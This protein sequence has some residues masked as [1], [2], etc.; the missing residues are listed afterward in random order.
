MKLQRKTIA[1]DMDGVIADVE[2]QYID[3]YKKD[4]GVVIDPKSMEGL[5]EHEAVPEA[6]AIMKF[7]TTPGFFRT[8]PVME[9]AV[10]ALKDLM[11]DYEVYIVSAAMEFPLSLYEKHQWLAEHFP[12]ISWKNIIFCGDKSVI[13][14]DYMIDDHSK[15]LDFHQGKTLMFNSFHNHGIEQHPRVDNWQEV[16][17]WFATN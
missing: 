16:T 11:Q 8:V 10:E 13:R 9:G 15:N 1:I 14:T 7:L 4:Y 5:M 12:F 17:E 2:K 6:G 3:W